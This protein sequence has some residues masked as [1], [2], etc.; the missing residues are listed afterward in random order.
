MCKGRQSKDPI[1]R[2][3]ARDLGVWREVGRDR[4]GEAGQDQTGRALNSRLRS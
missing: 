3:M 4:P 1:V 2:G